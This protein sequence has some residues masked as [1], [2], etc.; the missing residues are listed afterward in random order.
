MEGRGFDSHAR[1]NGTVLSDKLSTY[2]KFHYRLFKLPRFLYMALK[3][4][5]GNRLPESHRLILKKRQFLTDSMTARHL[6]P[7]VFG[8]IVPRD[9]IRGI[10]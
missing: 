3:K 9:H 8:I 1:V 2:C 7:L 6:G 10:S 5:N 4:S